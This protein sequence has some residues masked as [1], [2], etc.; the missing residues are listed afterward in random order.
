MAE[1]IQNCRK[2]LTS[3]EMSHG[4][5]NKNV[6]TEFCLFLIYRATNI[7]TDGVGKTFCPFTFFSVWLISKVEEPLYFLWKFFS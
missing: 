5:A 2:L 1:S 6:L 7:L 3:V 4:D